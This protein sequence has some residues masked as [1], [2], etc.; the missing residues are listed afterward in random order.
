VKTFFRRAHF[1]DLISSDLSSKLKS[2]PIVR[3]QV[4]P[5]TQDDM[6]GLQR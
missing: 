1:I 4:Q 6:E 2:L 3:K 5:L